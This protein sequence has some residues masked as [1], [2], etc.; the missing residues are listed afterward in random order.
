[1]PKMRMVVEAGPRPRYNVPMRAPLARH[2]KA[3]LVDEATG[4]PVPCQLLR[5]ELYWLL[6]YAPA[7]GEK[8]Y[9]VELGRGSSVEAPGVGAVRTDDKIEFSIG[10]SPFTTYNFGKEWARPFFYPVLGPDGVQI[11]RNYPML[12]G[13]PG[14][15]SDHHH[16]KSIWVAH[17]DVNGVDDWSEEKDHGRQV[18][19]RLKDLVD[20]PV[21]AVLRQDLEWVSHR[22]KRVMDEEREIRIYAVPPTE[23]M[24][25]LTVTFK[26]RCGKVLFG[27]TKEGGL[28]SVR[29]A[30][31]M[32]GSRG[33]KIENSYGGT[34]E[35]ECW[36]RPAPWCDY[37]GSVAGKIVGLA[38]FD[39]PGNLRYPTTWHVRDYG[40]MTAN[41]FG[42]S[43]F[44]P[45]S[46]ERGDH[47]LEARGELCF[48]YRI[49]MHLGDANQGHVRDKYHDY[50][51][52]P[53]VRFER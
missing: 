12:E 42:L 24:V 52:P 1:M 53:K 22:G 14:E 34:T 31:S 11:T 2:K 51:N 7:N 3:K 25:D 6:D 21:V 15:T 8:A 13:V 41:P 40:L 26:A 49:F 44:K 20:G 17:G 10:G 47:V 23:R 45:G 29:V 35:A 19:K 39:T 5:G 37:S 32:D 50:I 28:C 27:D 18:S 38:V 9:V 48:R 4:R 30:T 33:G 16:H 46:G 36:G 43:H